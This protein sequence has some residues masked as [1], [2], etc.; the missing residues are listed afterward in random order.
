[1]QDDLPRAATTAGN[2]YEVDLV[3]RDSLF[4]KASSEDTPR[5]PPDGT[6][7]TL[8]SA[9]VD[10]AL[11]EKSR[12]KRTGDLDTSVGEGDSAVGQGVTTGPS[13]PLFQASPS[14]TDD[15]RPAPPAIVEKVGIKQRQGITDSVQ[16]LSPEADEE[17][18]DDR[19]PDT[20]LETDHGEEHGT[21]AL[22]PSRPNAIGFTSPTSDKDRGHSWEEDLPVDQNG[23]VPGAIIEPQQDISGPAV[24]GPINVSTDEQPALVEAPSTQSPEP[25]LNNE[26]E[27]ITVGDTSSLM[28]PPATDFVHD[29]L[30]SQS[31][32][33]HISDENN[34]V[35][36]GKG[37]HVQN[38]LNRNM[39]RPT[40]GMRD[41]VFPGIN[42][43]SS[44]D[45]TL[46]RRPPMRIDTGMLSGKEARPADT[47]TSGS[48][49]VST[50]SESETPNKQTATSASAQ[51]PPERMTTRV[52]SGALRHK[53]VSE[54]LGETPRATPT[55]VDK[56]PF[57]RECGDTPRDEPR[58][59][60]TPKSAS[61]FTSPDIVAFK[62][63]LSELKEKERSKLSTVVFS[64]SRNPDI[65]QAQDPEEQEV[66]KI[67]RDYML[68]LFN[69]QVASPPRAHTLNA[70]VK[71][72]HKTLTTS[73]HLVDFTE[74][75]ACRML[76]KIY[77]LQAKNRWSFRQIER[78]AEPARPV[79]HWDVLLGEMKWMRTDFREE[80]K[81]KSA[82]ARHLA[83]ACAEW[84]AA[85][86]KD[87]KSLQVKVRANLVVEDSQSMLS[88][89]DLV[90][91]P[92][93]DTNE[94][95]A[96][97]LTLDPGNAP[98]AIFS[99]PPEM[100]VFG[101]NKSPVSENLLQELPLY[102]PNVDI[103]NA[104]LQAT[105]TD[106]DAP[107]KKPLV[108]VSKYVQGKLLS[109]SISERSRS[110]PKEEGPPR[111]RRRF[112][113][114]QS[115]KN[116]IVSGAIHAGNSHKL[117][118]PEQND[119]AL[120]DPE[121]KHIRDRIHSSHQFRPPS[122]YQMPSESFFVARQSSQWTQAEDDELRRNVKDFSYNWSLISSA[123]TF[124]SSFTSG[125]ERRTPWECFERWIG[126]EGLPVEMAK[127]NYF[128]AYHSRLQSA[129]QKTAE[130]QQAAQQSQG[131][132]MQ[133]SRRRTT[134]PYTVERRKDQRH[135]HLVDAMRKLAKK[136]ETALNKQQHGKLTFDMR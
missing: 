87:R 16:V 44:R 107:W 122:E 31:V 1:M 112:D 65:T 53:S 115:D 48:K 132:T 91:S 51:S 103:R 33:E 135:L 89:P 125:A 66:P 46:S 70:L 36:A 113:Y 22:Q 63:R 98:A 57:T 119:V 30:M 9:S 11:S 114:C 21:S 41:H 76:N 110:V 60:Q 40:S 117:L 62:R 127:I 88:T 54:I 59:L 75:Q 134:Q 23:S 6:T 130:A 14:F 85:S 106:P 32:V 2:D 124:P 3:G 56:S 27:E 104:A 71:S 90:H 24:S 100:F 111:K 47:T 19:V 82:A 120:F 42:G 118:D 80:R 79:T 64:S 25:L 7:I 28:P 34:E 58:F 74:R 77:E 131:N 55:Q 69:F 67:D 123:M 52:S 97:E 136:R 73:D 72:A 50:P 68:T 61:S 20:I 39:L 35:S 8:R 96:D 86:S 102:Q 37:I 49:T 83:Y 4:T 84:I 81:W 18:S 99:L 93:D 12:P 15:V 129:A 126:L 95:T 26:R 17:Q 116:N 10:G 45:L 5:P 78:S 108:P 105:K 109:T 121:Q 133:L 13:V 94:S 38:D 29:S 92:D 43:D 101:L 128:R